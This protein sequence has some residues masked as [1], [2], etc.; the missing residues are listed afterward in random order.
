MV[1]NVP[2]IGAAVFGLW[3]GVGSGAGSL[4][5]MLSADGNIA[6]PPSYPHADALIAGGRYAEAADFFR[7]H[8]RIEPGD[9]TAR[10]R[11]ADLLEE[12]QRDFG[13]AEQLYLEVRRLRPDARQEVAVANGLID[14]Y[15]RA[16]RPDRLKVELARFAE[17]YRGTKAGEAAGRELRELK[18]GEAGSGKRE[19]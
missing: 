4:V 11:L 1:L 3:R 8:I 19:G 13:G 10:L 6:P 15:R 9:L 17:R 12:H 18:G 14:L 5:R 16:G 2:L 7:D